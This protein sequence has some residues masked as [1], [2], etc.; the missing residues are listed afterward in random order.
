MKIEV[1]DCK[2][3]DTDE[4]VAGVRRFNESKIGSGNAKPLS[5]FA[6]DENGKLVGGVS[7]RTVYKHFL[8]E[9]VWV[10]DVRRGEGLGK[11]L[12]E[13]AESQA[14]ERGCVAAQV[15]TISFQAPEFYKK[16]GFEVAGMISE[17][18]AGHDRYFLC[19]RFG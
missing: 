8:I 10:D 14:I 5:V 1:I 3:E 2:S 9:V 4:L 12:M 18:P 17:F 7:G 19:K 13:I 15:D 11:R 16:L 6:R